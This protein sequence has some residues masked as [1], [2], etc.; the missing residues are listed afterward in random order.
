MHGFP[1]DVHAYAEVA[2][3]LAAQGCLVVVPYLRGF[4]PTRFLSEST[5][6]SGQQG[7]LGAEPAG[8]ARCAGAAARGARRLRLGRARGLHRGGAVARALRRAGLTRQLQHPKHRGLAQADR[9]VERTAALV[10]VLLS[11]RTRPRGPDGE[12]ARVV[13]VALA[14]V[15]AHVG[16]RRRHLRAQRSGL[17]QPRLRRRGDPFVPAPLRAGGR[18][19]R[20]RRDRTAPGGATPRSWCRPSPS[21]A[22]TTA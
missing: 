3:L 14:P 16:F 5:L 11:H 2:P 9:A 6:R 22:P 17:R 4:G 12:P 18:R 1:Y 7:A 20:L 8:A 19:P 10:P 15:V 21:T 13:P